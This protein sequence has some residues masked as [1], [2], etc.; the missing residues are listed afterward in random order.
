MSRLTLLSKVQDFAGR[1]AVITGGA[2]GIGFAMAERFA[3]EG[4]KVVLADIEPDALDAAVE[5]LRH[6]EFDVI[7]VVTDVSSSESVEALAART[8]EVYGKVHVLCNNAGVVGGNAGPRSVLWEA[9]LND[10]LWVTNVNY[11]GV[12]HGIRVF[13]PLM[14]S[15][16]EEGHVVNTSSCNGLMPGNGVYGATKHA[17]VSM[18]ESLYRD[19]HRL[20]TKLNV[21]CLCPGLVNT[22]IIDASR[23]RPQELRNPG[24]RRPTDEQLAR[25]AERAARG[26]E[27]GEV[28]DLVLE[29][30][31]ENQLYLVT[32]PEFNERIEDRMQSILTGRNPQY[33]PL[34]LPEPQP[35]VS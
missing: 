10:W 27:P 19:F 26:L 4:M 30:V 3:R 25:A 14:L 18:S 32:G 16:G 6:Q 22:G 1:V 13:V 2:S 12:A 9:S 28:A 29:A 5:N 17:I 11:W 21:T 35:R 23:N 15:H 8:I 7:G 31:R 34:E 33:F 24:D 20:N